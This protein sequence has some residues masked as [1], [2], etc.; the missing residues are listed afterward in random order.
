MV[1]QFLVCVRVVASLCV[2]VYVCACACGSVCASVWVGGVGSNLTKKILN[3]PE[4]IIWL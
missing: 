2:C 3:L 4:S 1:H